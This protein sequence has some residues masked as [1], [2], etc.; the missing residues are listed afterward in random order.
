M[1]IYVAFVLQFAD[2][3]DC[4]WLRRLTLRLSPYC[5]VF[6]LQEWSKNHYWPFAK[7]EKSCW[8]VT[9][10]TIYLSPTKI[11]PFF[12][13]I[14]YLGFY[15]PVPIFL[16]AETVFIFYKIVLWNIGTSW[17]TTC[18]FEFDSLINIFFFYYRIT[19][20]SFPSIFDSIHIHPSFHP[21]CFH[22]TNRNLGQS[23]RC[24]TYF[25]VCTY[26]SRY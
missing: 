16:A 7:N 13:L 1:S 25:F 19:V 21:P 6:L 24:I 8:K 12:Q 22:I 18:S 14:L 10:I 5:F 23:Y 11:E 17:K 26:E 20:R 9:L 15:S 4:D 2:D 3:S